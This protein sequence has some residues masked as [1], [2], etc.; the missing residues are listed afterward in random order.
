MFY[1]YHKLSLK[2]NHSILGKSNQIM[3]SVPCGNRAGKEECKPKLLNT[4]VI[5]GWAHPLGMFFYLGS[6]AMSPTITVDT[7]LHCLGYSLA[8]YVSAGHKVKRVPQ[9]NTFIHI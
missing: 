1:V 9:N 4:H 2:S 7:S 6:I 8:G 3:V 5:W